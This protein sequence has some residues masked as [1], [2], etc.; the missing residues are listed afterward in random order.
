VPQAAIQSARNPLHLWHL[1]SLDAP[2]VAVV[3]SLALAWAVPTRLPAWAPILLALVAWA[4]YIGDRLLDARAGFR[5]P[6]RQSLRER[7]YFHWRHRS[8]LT[9]LAL[10]SATGATWIVLALLPA[11][12]LKPDSLVAAATLAYF[13]G[14]HSRRSLP[15]CIRR[16]TAP[17]LSREFLVGTLFT[18][19]CVLPVWS[20]VSALPDA[21][22]HRLLLVPILYFAAL[23]WLNCRAIGRWENTQHNAAT[24]AIAWTALITGMVGLVLAKGLFATHPRFA[25]LLAAAAASAFLLALLDRVRPRVTA[26][27]LRATADLVLLT[28]ALVLLFPGL[29]R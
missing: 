27:T 1:A 25:A 8:I 28:P 15:V 23:A 24:S 7:H 10:V 22:A 5:A 6:S 20:Q 9:V 3:W 18:A 11:R 21:S 26:L 13:S 2:T 12:A 14:V 19:A 17:F 16:L 4:V 29:P